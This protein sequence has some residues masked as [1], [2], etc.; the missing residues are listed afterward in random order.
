MNIYWVDKTLLPSSLPSKQPQFAGAWTLQGVESVSQGCWP[1]LTPLLPTVVS[2]WLDF[3]WVVDHSWY[4]QETVECEKL[5]SVAVLDTLKPVGLAPYLVQRHFNLL[6]SPSMVHTHTI[7]VLIASRLKNLSWVAQHSKAL[8]LSS[9]GVNAVPGSNLG[10]ITSGRDWESHR[11]AH[12]WPY[13]VR[14]WPA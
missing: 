4:T 1:M 11:T 6:S 13:I 14:V 9:R 3:L 12:N 10:C 8:H 7:I 2:S 5:S